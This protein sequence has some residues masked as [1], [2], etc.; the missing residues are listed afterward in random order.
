M[1]QNDKVGTAFANLMDALRQTYTVTVNS[2]EAPGSNPADVAPAVPTAP[3]AP[4]APEQIDVQLLRHKFFNDPDAL[5][6]FN[7]AE[8]NALLNS[9]VDGDE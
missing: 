5:D 4:T 1:N 9:F 6:T 8:S 3:V 2:T 7:A